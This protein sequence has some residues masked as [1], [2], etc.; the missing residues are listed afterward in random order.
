M[1]KDNMYKPVYPE[2]KVPLRRNKREKET[3]RDEGSPS[4]SIFAVGN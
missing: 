1:T 3:E 4:K 2:L